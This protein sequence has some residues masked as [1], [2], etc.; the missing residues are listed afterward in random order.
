MGLLIG[1]PLMAQPYRFLFV[2]EGFQA[3]ERNEYERIANRME[4]AVR[5]QIP[6]QGAS[7][8]FERLFE[9]SSISGIPIRSR[10]DRASGQWKDGSPRGRTLLQTKI[11]D[12]RYII[13]ISDYSALKRLVEGYGKPVD[14][15]IVIVNSREYGAGGNYSDSIP[16][17]AYHESKGQISWADAQRHFRYGLTL[18]TDTSGP[19]VLLHE[20]GHSVANLGEEYFTP[21]Y[22]YPGGVYSQ[23]MARKDNVSEVADPKRVK[24]ADLMGVE[25]VG[26]FEGSDGFGRGLYRP[27]NDNCIMRRTESRKYCPVCRRSLERALRNQ[28]K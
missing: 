6:F 12:G 4:K 1:S 26:I 23:Y 19:G 24:W 11:A 8:E 2:S 17:T 27:W 18:I 9:A 7:L 16:A 14:N 21:G 13:Q 5:G 28:S 15:V 3:Q 20:L 22:P 10:Y 25:G